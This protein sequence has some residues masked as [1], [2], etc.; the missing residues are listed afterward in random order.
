MITAPSDVIVAGGRRF[1]IR[2]QTIGQVTG[3]VV[4]V[5]VRG[6]EGPWWHC[7][8]GAFNNRV[9]AVEEVNT[10]AASTLLPP[11]DGPL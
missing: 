10:L 6:P 1:L 5:Q 7:V 2:K 9:H 4:S 8:S 3:W 11:E